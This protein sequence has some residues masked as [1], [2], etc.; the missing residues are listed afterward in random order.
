[1]SDLYVQISPGDE[2]DRLLEALHGL[3]LDVETRA[4][5]DH[6]LHHAQARHWVTILVQPEVAAVVLEAGHGKRVQ[7]SP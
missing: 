3:S 6:D 7:I 1:M 4:Q 2:T 5:L